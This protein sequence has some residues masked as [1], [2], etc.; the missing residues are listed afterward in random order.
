MAALQ[1]FV[2]MAAGVLQPLHIKMALHQTHAG[3]WPPT[4]YIMHRL[5]KIMVP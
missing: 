4:E 5:P 3:L 1:L 2:A